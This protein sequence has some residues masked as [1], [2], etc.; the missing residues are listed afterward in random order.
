MFMALSFDDFVVPTKMAQFC[1]IFGDLGFRT[2]VLC[3]VFVFIYPGFFHILSPKEFFVSP[4]DALYKWPYSRVFTDC[5]YYYIFVSLGFSS[6][7]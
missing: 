4:A 6:E 3:R 5:I 7:S 2:N 1:G